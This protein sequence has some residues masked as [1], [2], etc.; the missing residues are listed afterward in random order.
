MDE[1][2]FNGY[3]IDYNSQDSYCVKDKQSLLFLNRDNKS[4]VMIHFSIKENS[5]IIRPR[6]GV[7]FQKNSKNHY[8]IIKNK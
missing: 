7:T 1:V 5:L 4:E 6:N 2:L 8:R 3:I